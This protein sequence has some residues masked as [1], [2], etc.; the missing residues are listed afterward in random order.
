M[1]IMGGDK[2]GTLWK[3]KRKS[4]FIDEIKRKSRLEFIGR[5][6]LTNKNIR[7]QNF[8]NFEKN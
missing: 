8:G 6:S 4:S 7:F 2:T 5:I 3:K 1:R